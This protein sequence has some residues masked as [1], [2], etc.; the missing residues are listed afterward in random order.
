MNLYNLWWPPTMNAADDRHSVISNIITKQKL[1]PANFRW[2]LC[3]RETSPARIVVDSVFSFF[4]CI[5]KT[6]QHEITQSP[7]VRT[8][9]C[10]APNA[11]NSSCLKLYSHLR[12]TVA[13]STHTKNTNRLSIQMLEKEVKNEKQQIVFSTQNY[14]LKYYS[15]VHNWKIGSKKWVHTKQPH[16]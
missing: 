8:D 9:Y 7:S 3:W 12:P 16:S 10:V 2:I 1:P 4:F 14:D 5:K 6:F 11:D 13:Y 15:N